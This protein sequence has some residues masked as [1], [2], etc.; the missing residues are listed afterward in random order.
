[1]K[2]KNK[3]KT[4]KKKI[5]IFITIFL[6]GFQ[7]YIFYNSICNTVD[8]FMRFLGFVVEDVYITENG[9]IP[10]DG[11]E[12]YIKIHRGDSIFKQT[13]SSIS[14]NIA[15]NPWIRD[16]T[17]HKGLPNKISITVSYKK[18]IAIFQKDSKFKLVDEKGEIITSIEKKNI[19]NNL[20]IVTG[21]DTCAAK[22]PDFLGILDKYPDIRKKLN[23]ISYIRERRWDIIV[24]GGILVKLP[25]SDIENALNNLQI[26]L[27]QPNI[28]K[29]TVKIIDMREKENVVVSGIKLKGNKPKGRKVT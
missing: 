19:K 22:V 27:K 12:N 26:M 14:E 20:P 16:I 29:N 5:F 1:M 18:P 21:E 8:N 15:R 9:T 24:S 17:V 7:F 2:I 10:V 3:K 4:N 25:Q 11:V 13:S 6:F 28:N 23:A